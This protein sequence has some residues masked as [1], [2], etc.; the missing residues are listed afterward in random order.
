MQRITDDD[1]RSGG[2]SDVPT[3]LAYLLIGGGIGALLALLFAP[4][5][6]QELRGDIADVTRKGIDRTRE[7]A[8]QLGTRA[9]DYYEA[10]KDRAAGIYTGATDKAGEVA[11]AARETLSRKG[12]QLSAA[13]EAG[14]QAY[15]E[16]KRK[17]ELTGLEAAGPNYKPEPQS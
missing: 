8:A 5:S 15:A 7:T 1:E 9:G 13:I 17:T 2:G 6:G 4:K 10:T 12:G 14:K 3:R 16:E 11:D